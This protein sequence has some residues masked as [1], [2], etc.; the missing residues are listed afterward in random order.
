MTCTFSDFEFDK[1]GWCKQAKLIHSP[2]FDSRPDASRVDLLVVHS[3]SL[4]PGHFG[5]PHIIE[6]FTN[7]LDFSAHPYFNQLRGMKVSAHFLI[8]RTGELV[9]FV[10]THNRAWHAGT[11]TFGGRERCN[12]FSIGVELEGTDHSAF[13]EVQYAVLAGLSRALLEQHPLTAV[14]GHEHIAPVR[15]TDPGPLF[16][17]L[18]YRSLLSMHAPDLAKTLRFP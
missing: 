7:R 4:P 8:T 2:N 1:N 11:S 14:V 3:I 18:Q 10:S 12:D 15:K 17:W 6:L 16:D 13:T 9:Q 5:G